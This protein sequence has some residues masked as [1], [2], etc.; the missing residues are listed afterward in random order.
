M[1]PI[2]EKILASG[3]IDRATAQYMEQIQLLPDGATDLVREDALKNATQ[4]HLTRLAED[5][6]TEVEKEHKVRETSLDL[7]RIKWPV[8]VTIS[9][10]VSEGLEAVRSS[11]PG[12]MDRMG[13]Y[14]FRVEEVDEAWF[15]PGYIVGRQSSKDESVVRGILTES[16]I[17]Y[18]GDAPVCWQVSVA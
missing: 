4:E 15:V 6:A 14:Y 17:L 5:L 18:V 1:K 11:I 3:L 2:V 16:Q 7:E 8:L 12:V 13:R 10:P 9:K